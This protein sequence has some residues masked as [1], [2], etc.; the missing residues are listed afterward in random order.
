MIKVYEIE[1]EEQELPE[2]TKEDLKLIG[3]LPAE[4]MDLPTCD[5]LPE[6]VD[7]S[8]EPPNLE[9][10]SFFKSR[11][12]NRKAALTRALELMDKRDRRLWRQFETASCWVFKVYKPRK[13]TAELGF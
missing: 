3:Q 13:A 12:P 2:L 6:T 1:A 7:Y 8:V 5:G 11:Y 10:I 9:T 4:A